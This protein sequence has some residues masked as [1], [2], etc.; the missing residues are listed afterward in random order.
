M[1]RKFTILGEAHSGK[2]CYLLAI[3]AAMAGGF[4]GYS[5][6]A[7]KPEVQAKL[8]DMYKA[9]ANKTL[10]QEDRFPEAS[11]DVDY[12]SFNL[13]YANKTILPFDWIDYPGG[14]LVL[15]DNVDREQYDKVAKN[16]QESSVLFICVDG[17]FLADKDDDNEDKIDNLKPL[18]MSINPYFNDYI[19]SGKK[20]PPVGFIVTKYD[21]CCSATTSEDLKKILS[22][23]F[24]PFFASRANNT[25]GIMP[26][27]LGQNIA[28]DN[29]HGKLRP[30][31]VHLPIFMGIYF[32]LCDQIK[33]NKNYQNLIDA[34]RKDSDVR[35]SDIS[36]RKNQ[37]LSLRD[38]IAT[39][40]TQKYKEEDHFF[41]FMKDM[42]KIRAL[43]NQIYAA[44]QDIERLE[45]A[46]SLDESTIRSNESENE[47]T[48]KLIQNVEANDEMFTEYLS[49]IMWFFDGAWQNSF[50]G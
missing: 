30:V 3:Y 41:D 1:G 35:R 45:S 50:R 6:R 37:L 43:E 7:Q 16:I 18:S 48:R 29:Y 31:N 12:Y 15:R 19:T 23:A 4:E 21:L 8:L 20:M 36:S 44:Q 22:K 32:A 14:N 11:F 49:H 33:T 10:D 40:R 28:A 34:N 42:N 39:L 24:S 13:G 9:L 38:R 25:V 17:E 26:V 2:T 47:R 27:S 5:I 46:I